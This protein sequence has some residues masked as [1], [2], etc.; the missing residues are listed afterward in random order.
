MDFNFVS[1]GGALTAMLNFLTEIVNAGVSH[2]GFKDLFL[3]S[4]ANHVLSDSTTIISPMIIYVIVIVG[5][6]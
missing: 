3:V 5:L 4:T 1:L 6:A 2:V